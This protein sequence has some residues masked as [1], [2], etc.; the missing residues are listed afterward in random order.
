MKNL[1]Q[2]N[3]NEG[4]TSQNMGPENVAQHVS[5]LDNI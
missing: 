5:S 1:P 4:N 2:E 3:K